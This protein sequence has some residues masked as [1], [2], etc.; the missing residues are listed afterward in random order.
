LSENISEF[1]ELFLAIN[2][3]IFMTNSTTQL[4]III[5]SPVSNSLSPQLHSKLYSKFNIP[6]KY[7][8]IAADIMPKDLCNLMQSFKILPI[9][10]LSV[11]I[12]HKVE[13]IEYLDDVDSTAMLIGAVNT[14]VKTKNILKGYN[15]D[16][17]GVIMPLA[18]YYG[19]NVS[20]QIAA[21]DKKSKPPK[22][23]HGKTVAILGAGGVARAA[24][25]A[26]LMAGANLLIF[27]RSLDKAEKLAEEMKVEFGSQDIHFFG[28]K[29]ISKVNFADIV[30]NCTSVGSNSEEILD[31]IAIRKEQIIFDL[32][33]KPKYTSLIKLAQKVG[34]DVIFGEDMFLYQALYQFELQTGIQ[35]T[36]KDIQE[37]YRDLV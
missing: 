20:Y 26:V 21:S 10:S 22:F 37:V 36:I 12:P 31:G 6:E 16:W 17:M 32:I 28:N 34:C 18:Q 8:F 33:Y 1:S 5:G 2:S 25:F 35:A 27:N 19:I 23:L 3:Y 9:N 4:N 29:Y 14:V 24:A 11:T 15:T 13:V 30:I 7:S